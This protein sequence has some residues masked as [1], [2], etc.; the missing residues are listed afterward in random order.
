MRARPI[1]F[2]DT[3]EFKITVSKG[4]SI[5]LTDGGVIASLPEG[6]EIYIKK[7]PFTADFPVKDNADFF[8]KVRNKLN[9]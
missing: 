9:G 5:V 2:S 4:K 1:V 8:A 7:A 6:A 3:E